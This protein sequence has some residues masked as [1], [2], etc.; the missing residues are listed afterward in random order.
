LISVSPDEMDLGSPYP[1]LLQVGAE[2][3]GGGAPAY[4]WNAPSGRFADASAPV[5]TFECTTAGVLTVSCTATNDG[6]VDRMSASLTCGAADG[7]S[8]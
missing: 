5:T 7:G 2:V 1:I 4:L 8:L 6:C 3:P